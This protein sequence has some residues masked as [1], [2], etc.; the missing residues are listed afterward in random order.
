MGRGTAC[1]MWRMA[2]AGTISRLR[3]VE[4]TST[5]WREQGK[6]HP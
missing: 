2:G 1:G 6:K 3:V 4:C 5:T